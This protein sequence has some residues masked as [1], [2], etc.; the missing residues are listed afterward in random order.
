ME[1]LELLQVGSLDFLIHF[2]FVSD[3]VFEFREG[4]R[5]SEEPLGNKNSPT[6]N[7]CN[8]PPQFALKWESCVVELMGSSDAGGLSK[9]KLSELRLRRR[10]PFEYKRVLK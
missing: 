8:R 3:F 6:S 2:H 1:I 4:E 9:S 7:R 5:E 10:S